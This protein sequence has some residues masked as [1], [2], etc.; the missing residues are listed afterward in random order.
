MA[1]QD[2]F[3]KDF[4]QVLGVSKDVTD[5]ELKKAYRKLARKYHPD[6]NP[7]DAAAEAKFKE[8]SEAYSVLSDPEQRKEYDAIR[9]MGSGA[10]FTAPGGA[11]GAGGFEDVFGDDVRRPG[12][13]SQP[14]V[15]VPAGRRLRRPARRDLRRRPVR[16]AERRLPRLRRSDPRPRRHR[17]D[18]AR[19]HHRHQGRADHSRDLGRQADHGAHPRR[20]RRRAE[21]QAPRQG[22]PVAR[23]RRVR[24]PHPHGPRAQAPGVRARRPQPAGH[25]AR[26]VRRG[27]PRR[28]DPGADPRRRPRQAARRAGHAERPRAARQGPRRPDVEGHGRPARRRAG[29]RAVAPVQ[30]GRGEAPGVRRAACPPRTR[31]TELLAKARAQR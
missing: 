14:V 21:D 16:P 25:R 17:V 28:H 20:R 24:R 15:H 19:L 31:A 11:G 29:R 4:Y 23:R 26:H 9:A 8:I 10:R 2:W 13:R 18:D 5:A 30:G 7:G 12:R 22:P 27:H 1:S 6:S 3:D